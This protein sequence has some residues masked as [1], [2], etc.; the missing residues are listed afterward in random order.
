MEYNRPTELTNEQLTQAV[1]QLMMCVQE[2]DRKDC[3]E[4]TYK[5]LFGIDKLDRYK[6]MRALMKMMTP[7]EIKEAQS[8]DEQ[9]SK[10]G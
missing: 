8:D 7:E 3:V 10:V 9:E 6:A 5:K 1:W 4:I 2:P